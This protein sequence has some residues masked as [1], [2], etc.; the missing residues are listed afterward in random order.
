M[1]EVET[2]TIAHRID[3]NVIR[4]GENVEGM[5]EGVQGVHVIVAGMNDKLESTHIDVQGVHREVSL[6]NTGDLFFPALA[7]GCVLSLTRLGVTEARE[8]MQ[9]VFKHVSDL[10]RS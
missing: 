2:L 10:N 3:E 5:N 4:V 1:A 8:E 7:L 6:I 9:V